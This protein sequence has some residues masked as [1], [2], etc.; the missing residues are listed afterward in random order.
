[1]ESYFDMEAEKAIPEM[2]GIIW[3]RHPSS[4][5]FARGYKQPKTVW[6]V[7]EDKLFEKQCSQIELIKSNYFW[8]DDIRDVIHIA[9]R[10]YKKCTNLYI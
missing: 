5:Y 4:E 10:T 3:E 1:M 8:S 6:E 2:K 7:F 9:N